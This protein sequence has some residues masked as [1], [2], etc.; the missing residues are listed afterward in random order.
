[1]SLPTIAQ[2]KDAINKAYVALQN[3]NTNPADIPLPDVVNTKRPQLTRAQMAARYLKSIEGNPNIDINKVPNMKSRDRIEHDLPIADFKPESKIGKRGIGF[4]TLTNRTMCSPDDY[5]SEIT[6]CEYE[7][8]HVAKDNV[9][10]DTPLLFEL[11][12]SEDS[13]CTCVADVPCFIVCSDQNLQYVDAKRKYIVG[14]HI[15]DY[16][17]VTQL[18]DKSYGKCSSRWNWLFDCPTPAVN[19]EEINRQIDGAINKSTKT[20][21]FLNQ[22]QLNDYLTHRKKNDAM[23]NFTYGL[24]SDD[25]LENAEPANPR[26]AAA[27]SAGVI[28]VGLAILGVYGAMRYRLR[29]SANSTSTTTAVQFLPVQ[30]NPTELTR[31][32]S[33]TAQSST[34]KTNPTGPTTSATNFSG[35]TTTSHTHVATTPVKPKTESASFKSDDA[36]SAS[37]YFAPAGFED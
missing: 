24:V 17:N 11:R 26:I 37:I 20:T 12:G 8:F 14:D 10:F 15:L 23:N 13:D 27:I 1:M 25:P 4:L 3:W 35:S 2:A 6:G 28:G 31:S 9:E 18:Y 21:I 19:P 33:T 7:L 5:D 16:R 22:A 30:T 29:K 34:V 36:V 32:T